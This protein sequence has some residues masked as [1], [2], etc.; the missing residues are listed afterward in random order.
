[1]STAI[2]SIYQK[3]DEFYAEDNFEGAEKYL[4]RE[5][6]LAQPCCG[7]FNPAYIT[8]MNE[9]GSLYRRTGKLDQAIGWFNKAKL[10]VHGSVGEKTVEYATTIS[11][12]A[13]TYRMAGEYDKAL[14]LFEQSLKIYEEIIGTGNYLYAAALNNLSLLYATQED[15]ASALPYAQKALE[16]IAAIEGSENETAITCANLAGLYDKLDMHEEA[17]E[18]SR[19][20]G[21]ILKNKSC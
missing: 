12:L 2:E 15:Y 1:M 13:D 4:T 16:V 7:G 19:R 10:I 3:L 21:E 11:N 18:A 14:P 9:L 8:V 5:A 17:V 20:A 6:T